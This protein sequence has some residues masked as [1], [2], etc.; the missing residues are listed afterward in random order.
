M[1]IYFN[2]ST[3]NFSNKDRQL[4]LKGMVDFAFV[5][6]GFDRKASNENHLAWD[7]GCKII[8]KIARKRDDAGATILDILVGKIVG[9]ATSV[10]Q[11]TGNFYKYIM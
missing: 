3:S 1:N 6:L 2:H 11:Y 4:V 9:C 5:L 7:F 10:T 8:Q